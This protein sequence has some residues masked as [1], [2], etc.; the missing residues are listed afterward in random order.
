[1]DAAAEPLEDREVA[2]DGRRR[3]H[4]PHVTT[5][6]QNAMTR[7]LPNTVCRYDARLR[8]CGNSTPD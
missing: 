5:A 7:I 1:M 4:M 6:T 8:N 3:T 2:V